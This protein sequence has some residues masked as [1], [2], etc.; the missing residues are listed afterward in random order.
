[1]KKK[2]LPGLKD[3]SG[4]AASALLALLLLTAACHQLR[5]LPDR[6]M[7]TLPD[8]QELEGSWTIDRISLDRMKR[9]SSGLS[10]TDPSDHLLLFRKDKTCFFKTYW[11]FQSDSYYTASEGHW[12]LKM[13]ETVAGS[14]RLR[15]AAV[16][17][18]LRTNGAEV[19][20]EFWI[21]RE[22]NRLVL[23]NYVDDP[24]YTQ[25]ADFHKSE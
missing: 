11:A 24:D 10:K 17:T 3:P 13:D 25:Y 16:I 6:H 23:W 21:A 7:S 22:N 5:G 12:K 1:M 2:A 20:A 15:A 18:L 14:G 9:S 19:S 8:P 4:V